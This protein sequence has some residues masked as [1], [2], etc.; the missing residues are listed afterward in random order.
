MLTNQT[1]PSNCIYGIPPGI[2]K[3][4]LAFNLS[5]V[6]TLHRNVQLEATLAD[7]RLPKEHFLTV[8]LDENKRKF[9]AHTFYNSISGE[10]RESGFSVCFRMLKLLPGMWCV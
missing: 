1:F 5:T 4:N 8:P 6:T 2:W 7:K 9:L 10:Q 3:K